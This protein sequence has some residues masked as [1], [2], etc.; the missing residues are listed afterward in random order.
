MFTIV[1]SAS[2]P[3]HQSIASNTNGT[4]NSASRRVSHETTQRILFQDS[5]RRIGDRIAE[6][7]LL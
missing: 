1:P 6:N 5:L 3:K 7:A 4:I 2:F